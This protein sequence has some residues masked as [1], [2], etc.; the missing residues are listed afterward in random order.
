MTARRLTPPIALLALAVLVFAAGCGSAP[1]EPAGPTIRTVHTETVRAATG[2]SG[3]TFS[4]TLRAPLEASLSFRVPGHVAEVRVDAGTEVRAGDLIARLDAE[5]YRLEVEAARASLRQAEAAAEN[6]R[7]EFR[8]MKALYAEDNASASAYD[9]A[10]TTLER[11]TGQEEAA[12]R[13][14]DLAEKRLGYTRLTA[15]ATGSVAQ[16][17]VEAG[18][19]VSVGQPVAHLTSRGR[20]EVRIQVP[21]DLISRVAT[22]QPATVSAA[23]MGDRTLAATVTEVAS[24]PNGR[25]PTYPVV[26]TLDRAHSSLR[27]GMTARVALGFGENEG[28]PVP[29]EAVNEDERGRFVYIVRRDSASVSPDATGDVA[30]VL[31]D[32]ADGRI[33]RR[34]VTTGSIHADGLLVMEGLETG[35]RI[36]TAGVAQIREGDP[37]RIS[38]LLS[39]R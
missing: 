38:R 27:S 35:D 22:G 8:R 10:R 12:Q 9:R 30:A 23:T 11:A 37:V 29:P 17:H 21:E 2:A 7:A 14:L 33:E 24:A 16:T 6:A 31:P 15:P 5:D 20:L 32:G 34:T 36:V 3:R 25:Q 39:Q 28:F 18:E 4:G 19:N 1:D 26:V 13:R